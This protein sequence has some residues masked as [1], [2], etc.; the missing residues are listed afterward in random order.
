M[1]LVWLNVQILKLLIKL[2]LVYPQIEKETDGR[3]WYSVRCELVLM[4]NTL[5][6]L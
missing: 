4:D 3:S 6:V 1:R 2:L 5:D